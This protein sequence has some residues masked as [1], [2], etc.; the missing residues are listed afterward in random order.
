MTRLWLSNAANNIQMG[1]GASKMLANSMQ[2][3]G[4]GGGVGGV[5][6]RGP[7]SYMYIY[8]YI[9]VYSIYIYVYTHRILDINYRD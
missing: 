6:V 3:R 7:G 8:M 2:I 1:G 9:Y 4:L 5:G